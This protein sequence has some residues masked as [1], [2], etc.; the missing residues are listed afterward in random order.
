[1]VALSVV[2]GMKA[3]GVVDYKSTVEVELWKSPV[4][5]SR[6]SLLE[7]LC[8]VPSRCHGYPPINTTQLQLQLLLL[9]F[10]YNLY[11]L[12]SIMSTTLQF[13]HY[14]PSITPLRRKSYWYRLSQH[15][16]D[17]SLNY[18]FYRWSIL[19][20]LLFGLVLIAIESRKTC[21]N[22]IG[23]QRTSIKYN[24]WQKTNKLK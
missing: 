9:L 18:I 21:T 11:Y 3:S 13:H 2:K 23:Q 7:I 15:K 12:S 19:E 20:K 22:K 1:M 24:S 6:T 14:R 5:K 16:K 4:W 10:I 17:L 8:F